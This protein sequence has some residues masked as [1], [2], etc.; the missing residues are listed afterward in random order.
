MSDHKKILKRVGL[1]IIIFSFID[2][3]GKVY[4]L[5]HEFIYASII[6]IVTSIYGIFLI[7]GSLKAAKTVEAFSALFL[8]GFFSMVILGTI[9]LPL[10]MIPII[11]PLDIWVI[12]YQNNPINTVLFFLSTPIFI[13]MLF[14]IY[15]QLRSS[16]VLQAQIAKGESASPPKFSF[17]FGFLIVFILTTA[18]YLTVDENAEE[19]A[20][21]LAGTQLGSDYKYYVSSM[22]WSDGHYRAT[23]DAYRQNEIKTVKVKWDNENR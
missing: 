14:W 8:S 18:V 3:T 15:K 7:F 22:S 4:F 6:D 19:K 13:T 5:G 23:V 12:E 10:Y 9:F 21:K 1:V 17:V 11:K 16:V 2:V 20:I